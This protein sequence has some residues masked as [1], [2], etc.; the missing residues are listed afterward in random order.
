MTGYPIYC[1]ICHCSFFMAIRTF[2]PSFV[3]FP[4]SNWPTLRAFKT[5]WPSQ[6]NQIINAGLLRFKHFFKFHLVWWIFHSIKI[7]L[8]GRW[9]DTPFKDNLSFFE[10]RQVHFRNSPDK[11]VLK[12]VGKIP[13][14]C[15]T[16]K[17]RK[18][19]RDSEK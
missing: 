1:I 13:D 8:Y 5:I 11:Q 15:K 16:W 17:K 7:K 10:V 6:W 4:E 14:F 18:D 12:M 3:L 9:S 19:Q 2:K